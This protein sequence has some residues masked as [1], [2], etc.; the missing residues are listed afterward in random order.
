MSF[1]HP[2]MT[3]RDELTWNYYPCP[4]CIGHGKIVGKRRAKILFARYQ[5]SPKGHMFANKSYAMYWRSHPQEYQ[6]LMGGIGR[7]RMKSGPSSRI[8]LQ[9]KFK[10]QVS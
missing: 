2:Q 6:A 5:G 10:P 1:K 9:Q 7:G 3:L 8:K 4:G